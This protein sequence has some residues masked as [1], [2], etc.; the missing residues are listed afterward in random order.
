[1]TNINF[2]HSDKIALESSRAENAVKIVHARRATSIPLQCMLA[3]VLAWSTVEAPW[4]IVYAG[5]RVEIGIILVS[6]VL[7]WLV[8]W[9]AV[10][11]KAWAEHTALY[12]CLMSVW[13]VAPYLSVELEYFPPAFFFSSVELVLKATTAIMLTRHLFFQRHRSS[14]RLV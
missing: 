2:D 9:H 7:L 14:K 10:R 12:L 13:A 11:G 6:K 8:L 5:D 4:E 3:A 1:M